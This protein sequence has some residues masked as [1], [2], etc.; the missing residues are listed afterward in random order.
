M[1]NTS[2]Q[3]ARN[4]LVIRSVDFINEPEV[5]DEVGGST[6]RERA[7]YRFDSWKNTK[8][9]RAVIE[10]L[11]RVQ[12]GLCACCKIDVYP[13]SYFDTGELEFDIDYKRLATLDHIVPHSLG[14]S[15]ELTNL[16]IL[17]LSCNSKKGQ[18]TIDYRGVGNADYTN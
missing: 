3:L 14:G 7:K 16:Q 18:K 17:C 9:G 13:Y 15:H 12:G 5:K 10:E 1:G 2:Y 11:R 4:N 6:K 8:H